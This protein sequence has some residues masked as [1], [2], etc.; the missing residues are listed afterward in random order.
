M[1]DKDVLERLLV[2]A[3]QNGYKFN[4]TSN[5]AYTSFLVSSFN[6]QTGK[7]TVMLKSDDNRQELVYISLALLLF[8]ISF[9]KSVFGSF[10]E[11]HLNLLIA[12]K[13]KVEYIR[14]YLK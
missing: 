10:W 1:D 4:T 2:R 7:F 12:T 13:D 5:L 6:S 14:N 11:T 3:H 9:A 8:D